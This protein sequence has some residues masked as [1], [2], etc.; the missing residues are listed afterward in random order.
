MNKIVKAY[1]LAL[2]GGMLIVH[3]WWTS[4]DPFI[5]SIIFEFFIAHVLLVLGMWSLNPRTTP[6]R[7][8]VL[9]VGSLFVIYGVVMAAQL[10]PGGFEEIGLFSIVIPVYLAALGVT[11]ITRAFTRVPR[12]W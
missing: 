7:R 4:L 6:E 3:W 1:L 2:L 11:L 5:D 9:L 12:F 10:I 8:I